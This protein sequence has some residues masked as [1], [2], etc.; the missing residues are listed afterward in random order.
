MHRLIWERLEELI[1]AA[2][3]TAL[4]SEIEAHL[5]VCQH[6]RD[7]LEGFRDQARLLRVLRGPQEAG[8]AAGFYARVMERV[9]ARRS[10]SVWNALLD[11]AFAWRLAFGSLA[12]LLALSGFLAINEASPAPPSALPV[13]VI[14]LEEHPPDLGA[15]LQRDRDTVLVTLATYSE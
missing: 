7:R 1:Q 8:P 10:A 13:S 9:E 6:C 12:A 4:S 15:D 11:P 3:G 5:A 14:A 2:P